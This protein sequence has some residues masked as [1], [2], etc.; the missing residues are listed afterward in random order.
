MKTVIAF[1]SLVLALLGGLLFWRN[2]KRYNQ[3]SVTWLLGKSTLELLILFVTAV[4]MT[5][6]L[7]VWLVAWATR[8]IKNSWLRTI[9]AVLY[10]ITF[11]LLSTFALEV[12]IF[13]GIFSIDMKTGAHESSGFLA[14]WKRAKDEESQPAIQAA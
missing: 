14:C 3:K 9:F 12:L 8:P 2:W 7:I 1:W 5:P 10:G 4:F 13:L 6:L 11:G